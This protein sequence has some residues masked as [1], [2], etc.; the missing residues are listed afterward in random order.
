[1]KHLPSYKIFL[2]SSNALENIL[3]RAIDICEK[4]QNIT[5]ISLSKEGN[6]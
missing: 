1:M 4:K 3:P 5:L 2:S 6:T